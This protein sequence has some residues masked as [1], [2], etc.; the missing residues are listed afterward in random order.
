MPNI[1]E[2]PSGLKPF[3]VDEL[4][5]EDRRNQAALRR[6]EAIFGDD[7]LIARYRQVGDE[8]LQFADVAWLVIEMLPDKT[9][10]GLTHR[11]VLSTKLG[12]FPVPGS[13]L[14]PLDTVR[15]LFDFL[16]LRTAAEEDF[17]PR[18]L[19]VEES[20]L[21][22]R[23]RRTIWALWLGAQGLPVHPMLVYGMI[24]EHD[25]KPPGQPDSAS[26]RGNAARADT[27]IV[28]RQSLGEI[29]QL[30]VITARYIVQRM[31][32]DENAREAI[33]RLCGPGPG[34][35]LAIPGT[36]GHE[37]ML[38]L[39]VTEINKLLKNNN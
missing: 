20:P 26:G 33:N 13:G 3:T 8:L 39:L 23:A 7:G 38:R 18:L 12:A 17:A 9:P 4:E 25:A 10:A 22:M 6:G 15:D 24:I 11:F 36:G 27:T 21:A 2:F 28:A 29:H 19:T 16:H 14:G 37:D 34:G 32:N 5:E 1:P 30:R 31:R 35:K